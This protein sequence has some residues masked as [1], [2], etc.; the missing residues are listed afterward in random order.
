MKYFKIDNLLQ[1]TTEGYQFVVCITHYDKVGMVIAYLYPFKDRHLAENFAEE[2]M[3]YHPEV[4]EI[5]DQSRQLLDNSNFA[6]MYLSSIG[7]LYLRASYFDNSETI[8]VLVDKDLNII[9]VNEAMLRSPQMKR[10][11]FIGKNLSEISSST[12]ERGLDKAFREVIRTGKSIIL[13]DVKGDSRYGE[14]YFK[15]KAFKV[16]NGVGISASNINNLINM[17]NV[18]ENYV[19]KSSHDI[20]SPISG[21]LGLLEIIEADNEKDP[22]KLREYLSIIHGQIGR[23]DELTNML[24][25]SVKLEKHVRP[26]EE[27]DFHK[28]VSDVQ[29]MLSYIDGYGE[30]DFHKA[31]ADIDGYCFD[32]TVL[33]F[34][35]QNLID[36][37]IKYRKRNGSEAPYVKIEVKRISDGIVITIADNGLGIN[38]KKQHKIFNIFFR[39]NE[40]L[41]GNGLGLYTLKNSL[42]KLNGKI[43]MHSVENQG[44]TFTIF[45]PLS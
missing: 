26:F 16:G 15:V 38:E 14:D 18:L 5:S 7:E 9:D 21:V 35:F 3:E 37:A 42:E 39:A 8:Y 30:V 34:L 13:D 24:L 36:N 29:E 45:L 19:Y 22:D 40:N 10:S 23:L 2:C 6:E 43:A 12:A 25:Q 31:I 1:L 28:I 27:I 11:Q 4:L 20:R 41:P 44:T 32:K 17:I 33:I